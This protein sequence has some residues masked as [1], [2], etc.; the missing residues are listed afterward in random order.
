MEF[1]FYD[2][3]EYLYQVVKNMPSAVAEAKA[4]SMDNA[5][6][7]WRLNTA[8]RLHCGSSLF[9]ACGLLSNTERI[10]WA[11]LGFVCHSHEAGGGTIQTDLH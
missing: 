4:S 10:G 1:V 2:F 8:S 5:V 7:V 3:Y 9:S 6:Y 11:V